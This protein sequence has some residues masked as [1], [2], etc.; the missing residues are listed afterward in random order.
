MINFNFGFG[1]LKKFSTEFTTST[2]GTRSTSSTVSTSTTTTFSTSFSTTFSTCCGSRNTSFF[3][4]F[5]YS[6][7]W[8][9]YPDFSPAAQ[10]G[11]IDVPGCD[12][13]FNCNANQLGRFCKGNRS[14]NA[15]HPSFGPIRLYN[16]NTV[17]NSSRNTS[18]FRNTTRNTSRNTSC[19]FT[20]SF[21]TTFNTSFTTSA[22]TTRDTT[23]YIT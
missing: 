12:T 19:S 18:L 8:L 21:N 10:A 22:I 7:G 11:C 3:G 20:T 23:F 5:S 1:S 13:V 17:G 6:N 15:T 14:G 16:V 9:T 4:T 2:S